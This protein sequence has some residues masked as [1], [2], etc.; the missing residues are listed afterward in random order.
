MKKRYQVVRI[1]VKLSTYGRGLTDE[2]IEKLCRKL[3]KT[4]KGRSTQWD[5]SAVC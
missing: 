5:V 2:Q 4:A 1:S 3:E